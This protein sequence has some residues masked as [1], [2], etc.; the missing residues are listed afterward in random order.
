MSHHIEDLL[1]AWSAAPQDDWVLAVVTHVEGSAY[2]KVGAM[3]LIH[4]MGKSV[5]LVSGGCL[6]AD[7]RRRAQKVIQTGQA[8]SVC[9]DATDEADASYQLGCGGLV[10]LMLLPLCAANHYLHFQALKAALASQGRC[11]Y[12][13]MLT[14]E[15]LSPGSLGAKVWTSQ[16]ALDDAKAGWQLSDFPRPGILQGQSMQGETVRGQS[17]QDESVQGE[18]ASLVVPLREHH[19]IAIFGGGL[20]AQPVCQI[21]QQLGWRVDV[22][23]RRTSYAREYDFVGANII[24]LPVSELPKNFWTRLDGAIVMQ[25]NLEL[26]AKALAA[27]HQHAK[28]LSYLALLGPG[29]RRDRV[30]ALAG[31][32]VASFGAYFSAPAGLALGGELPSSI[33]LSI[34]S[35]CHGV[36]HGAKRVAL[37]EVMA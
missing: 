11:H 9:Y 16:Q 5:G 23:D 24:K 26:D 21:A 35:E 17:L 2:R 12:Q 4:G 34:L 8:A 7:L 18:S 29:H 22:V 1:N 28:Q 27:I 32:E 30:L 36:L 25:H 31:L 3:M 19:R 10:H 6:E 14:D 15:S 20:D 13:L 37:K 33:A